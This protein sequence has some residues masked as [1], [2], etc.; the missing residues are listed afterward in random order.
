LSYVEHIPAVQHDPTGASPHL[1][2]WAPP[3]WLRPRT[4]I[5][6]S[7]FLSEHPAVFGLGQLNI[8]RVGVLEPPMPSSGQALRRR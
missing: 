3:T 1:P 7:F 5:G 8:W 4:S 2:P 6:H